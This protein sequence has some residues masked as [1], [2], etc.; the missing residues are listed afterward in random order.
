MEEQ[1]ETLN[2]GT[3]E[4]PQG[5][6]MHVFCSKNGISLMSVYVSF[7]PH[8]P[9]LKAKQRSSWAQQLQLE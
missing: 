3:E 1:F 4:K 2:E 7:T 9:L 6:K 5:K 8:K